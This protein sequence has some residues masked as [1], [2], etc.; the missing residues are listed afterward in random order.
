MNMNNQKHMKIKE[1][2]AFEAQAYELDEK[3]IYDFYQRKP[4]KERIYNIIK[5]QIAFGR[6][7]AF[8]STL[9]K[10]K[11]KKY[12][13]Y[14]IFRESMQK[15]VDIDD[16][17]S[18]IEQVK[19]LIN[20][21]QNMRDKFYSYFC[22]DRADYIKTY[23]DETLNKFI[24]I[25]TQN[26]KL[27][28]KTKFINNDEEV[29]PADD[30]LRKCYML[31]R[32]RDEDNAKEIP[33]SFVMFSELNVPSSKFDAI[34]YLV[35]KNKLSE[36]YYE[37]KKKLIQGFNREERFINYN[38]LIQQ[39]SIQ[40]TP[41]NL[42]NNTKDKYSSNYFDLIYDKKEENYYKKI[43]QFFSN[44]EITNYK[45]KNEESILYQELY[46]ILCKNN[47]LKFLSYL[48][49]K[50]K[51]FKYIYDKFSDKNAIYRN[52]LDDE[53]SEFN[54]TSNEFFEEKENNEESIKEL[55]NNN[56]YDFF[57][58]TSKKK[59]NLG[60]G[61]KN[62]EEEN[63]NELKLENNEKL[64]ILMDK[65]MNNYIYIKIGFINKNIKMKYLKE[66]F[67][68]NEESEEEK[69]EEKDNNS[70]PKKKKFYKYLR[71][72]AKIQEL[73]NILLISNNKNFIIMNNSLE[74][75]FE[76][77]MDKVK[78][79]KINKD[80][81][82]NILDDKELEKIYPN[83]IKAE[84]YLY[85]VINEKGN[86]E[87]Y[88]FKISLKNISNF[89]KQIEENFSFQKIKDF[90]S[91]DLNQSKKNIKK[92]NKNKSE[93]SSLKKN[94]NNNNMNSSLKKLSKKSIKYDDSEK[95]E[96]EEKKKEENKEEKQSTGPSPFNP[97]ETSSEKNSNS[98]SILNDN[99][100][101]NENN[102]IDKIIKMNNFKKTS[103]YQKEHKNYE[104]IVNNEKCNFDITK[105]QLR[106]KLSNKAMDKISLKKIEPQNIEED[107]ENGLYKM[108]LKKKEKII[109]TLISND[110]NNLENFYND[111]INEKKQLD[112]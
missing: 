75:I 71:E 1:K 42:E 58:N 37:Q 107:K 38:K 14:L 32:K 13:N 20:S 51:I 64:N 61:F 82:N 76:Y 95:S 16:I 9:N 81:L 101:E 88:L 84:Y 69:E 78:I 93:E 94:I 55:K 59:L 47:Y 26:K 21:S 85:Q 111:I 6:D 24:N 52:I 97:N 106:Y 5:K 89:D 63:K 108:D 50:N 25:R 62:N 19:S 87:F 41:D 110:K 77:K 74:N 4:K 80:I 49:S 53:F 65:I 31:R 66:F 73:N 103:E 15:E 72:C 7:V 43:D 36:K 34:N 18:D 67:E 98:A 57:Y 86:K 17:K 83:K 22:M 33:K 2:Y 11:A 104:F 27:E 12:S 8:K 39:S 90:I 46:N 35:N 102:K 10:N 45:L 96:K 100:S 92:E 30:F 60:I 105:G 54:T 44:Y 68:E 3:Q 70:K 56:N 40:E 112:Y 28:N 91:T 29:I 48:Y 79:I 99:S 23:P 109:F